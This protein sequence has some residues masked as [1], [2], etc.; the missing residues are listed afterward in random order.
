MGD[1]SGIEW[2]DA[3]WNPTL[4]C[5]KVSPGC[6][7]CYA[8]REAHRHAANPNPKVAAAFAGLTQIQGGRP[9]WTGQVNLLPDRLDQ[10]LRWQRPRRVFL[11]SLS[12][13]FHAEVPFEYLDR[14]FAVMAI[15]W[16]HQFQI[17]TKRPERMLKYFEASPFVLSERWKAEARLIGEEFKFAHRLDIPPGW[18][19]NNVWLGVST[20]DQKTAN[21]RIPLLLQC[22]AVIRWVSAEPLLGPL[23][24][25]KIKLRQL[26]E[27]REA[28]TDALAGANFVCDS[29]AEADVSTNR[30]DW[31]VAGG[32]SGPGARPMHPDWARGLRDDCQAAGVPYLFKQW[33]EFLPS[34]DALQLGKSGGHFYFP[35]DPEV[36]VGPIPQRMDRV[37]KKAAGRVLDGREWNEY[38]AD[39]G[40]RGRS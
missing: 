15:A 10:P 21:A 3:T 6:T 26:D 1:K 27:H 7:H 16:H 11:D 33:G 24:L 20:E 30:I 35:R 2:T 38:P 18:P 32:E 13:L 23:D 22:P 36:K 14:V 17:L 19:L 31:V 40:A 25:T 29:H 34:E 37:G 8:I 39:N 9:N 5:D 28:W 12:D 4:G